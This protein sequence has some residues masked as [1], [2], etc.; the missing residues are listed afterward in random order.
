MKKR[1]KIIASLCAA[2]LAGGIG[3]LKYLNDRE[4]QKYS[5]NWM[6][7]L[8]DSDLE[9]ER[10]KVRLAWCSAPK[11]LVTAIRLESILNQFDKIMSN[12]AGN[13]NTECGYPKH[14]EHGWY[15][16]GDD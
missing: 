5:D 2:V 14:T 7:S 1:T 3:L 12:R 6:N 13:D 4:S 10:E 16:S 9:M 8:S 11:D 15:L